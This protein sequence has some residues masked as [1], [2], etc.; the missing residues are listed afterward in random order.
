MII[1]ADESVD[2]RIVES[3]RNAEIVVVAI[4]EESPSISDKDVLNIAVK[5]NA[6]LLT[7]DKDFGELVF[8]LRLPHN[9]ILLI[10]IFEKEPMIKLIAEIIQKN[11][12]N[13]MNNFSVLDENKLRIKQ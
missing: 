5:K 12:S 1:V 10:R 4:A 7:E 3:L 13:L 2:F 9:G 11:Y 8:R 6:L